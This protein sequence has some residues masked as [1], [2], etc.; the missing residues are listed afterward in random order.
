MGMYGTL[1]R[2]SAADVARL[3]A[4]P[5]LVEPFLFGDAPPMV[6]ERP[7]GLLGFLLRFTPITI[8]RAADAPPPVAGAAPPSPQGAPDESV[9]LDKA[10]HGLHFLLTGTADS[11]EEPGCFV[12][13]GGEDIGEDDDG[14]PVARLLDPA[15]VRAFDA[16][17]DTLTPEELRSR[18]DPERMTALEIYP[19]VIWTRPEED[20]DSLGFLL[21]AFESLRESIAAAAAAGDSVVITVS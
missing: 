6:E 13:S 9:H 15:Q 11:E 1:R 16:F 19:A 10:W 4:N 21:S 8:S 2:A 17:L 3:R 5:G 20:D 18:F 14:D 7:R 12:I